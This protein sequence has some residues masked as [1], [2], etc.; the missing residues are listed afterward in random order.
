MTVQIL[1]RQSLDVLFEQ[2]VPGHDAAGLGPSIGTCEA[3]EG[4]ASITVTRGATGATERVLDEIWLTACFEADVQH[5]A[6]ELSCPQAVNVIRVSANSHGTSLFEV[7]EGNGETSK[8]G[9]ASATF[10][11]DYAELEDGGALLLDS[12]RSAIVEPL[13]SVEGS[14]YAEKRSWTC[15]GD[16]AGEDEGYDLAVQW[17]FDEDVR[18]WHNLE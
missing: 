17:N 15:V 6:D 8:L 13:N 7:W 18:V 4:A 5:L 2:T 9:T 3:S 14:L 11:E 16:Q 10:G 1:D 12:H